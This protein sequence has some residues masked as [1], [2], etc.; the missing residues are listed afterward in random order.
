M[1]SG[2]FCC[3]N[4]ENRIFENNAFGRFD[5]CLMGSF[6]KDFRV[7]LAV[8]NILK[9]N[10]RFEVAFDAAALDGQQKVIAWA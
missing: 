4:A 8:P 1:H 6:E 9:P 7:W 2:G 10:D 5:T 3:L